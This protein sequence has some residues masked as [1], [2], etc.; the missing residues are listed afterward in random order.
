[1]A[2]ALADNDLSLTRDSDEEAVLPPQ[3]PQQQ[4]KDEEEV[5]GVKLDV[6]GV[7]LDVGGE[8]ADDGQL[9]QS[10]PRLGTEDGSDMETVSDICTQPLNCTQQSIRRLRIPAARRALSLK[11]ANFTNQYRY[12]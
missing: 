6:G 10:T 3:Q 2:A 5:G 1:M 9:A 11:L 12:Q 4:Q 7:K 8:I